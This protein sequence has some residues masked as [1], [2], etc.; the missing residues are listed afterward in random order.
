[1]LA[2]LELRKYY[3]FCSSASTALM[4]F[5]DFHTRKERRGGMNSYEIDFLPVGTGERSGDA[6]CVRYGTPGNYKVM[7]YDGGTKESGEKLVEHIK[8]FY[9]TSHVDYVV[10]SHPDADHASG[11][12]VVVEQLSVGE[13]WMH[14]PWEH[15]K[16][17]L[18]YFHD[19]RITDTSLANRL[20]DKMAAAYALEELAQEKDIPIYEPFQGAKIGE[21][22]VLSPDKDWYV[23]ELI[24]DFEKSPDKK[25]AA[26]AQNNSLLRALFSS[27]KEGLNSVAESWGFETLRED[28]CTSAEN[29]SSVVLFGWIADRGIL[30]TGDA[31]VQA[32]SKAAS[33]AEERNMSIPHCI[34]FAQVPH[35]GSRNN[36]SPSVLNRLLGP[37][38]AS[39]VS[40]AQITAFVSAGKGSETHPR[41][42]VVNAFLRRNAKVMVTRA[43]PIRHHHKMG[44]R[45]GW[46]AIDS[47]TFSQEVES[48]N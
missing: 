36:V 12:S 7:V 16:L 41:K 48:W 27:A 23:H 18:D 46:T 24:A 6:I 35:H 25:Q 44:T 13:L 19:G 28:V 29:E 33:Y 3:P 31:G 30:L 5:S 10:C 2:T 21:F 17:I 34:K 47:L 43:Q 42:M 39:P 40:D 4:R 15:S 8:T 1:V 37:R 32:L 22:Y 38:S 9:G 45:A 26:Y 20:K 14:R 11:L